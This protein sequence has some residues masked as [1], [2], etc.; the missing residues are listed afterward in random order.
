MVPSPCPLLLSGFQA[1][2]VFLESAREAAGSSLVAEQSWVCVCCKAFPT[3]PFQ[4]A[5]TLPSLFVSCCLD[6]GKAGGGARGVGL[7]QQSLAR[8]AWDGGSV[9]CQESNMPGPGDKRKVSQSPPHPP[10]NTLLSPPTKSSEHCV[11]ELHTL[12][13]GGQAAQ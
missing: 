4:P 13:P 2:L 3:K 11:P 10:S 7:R 9:N 6:T 12:P 5:L 8:A 1:C